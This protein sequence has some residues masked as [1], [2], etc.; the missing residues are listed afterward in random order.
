MPRTTLLISAVILGL[1]RVAPAQ[2]PEDQTRPQSAIVPAA[3]NNSRG[4]SQDYRVGIGDT[5]E[6]QVIEAETLNQTIRVSSAGTINFLPVGQIPVLDLTAAELEA[7]IAAVLQEAKLIQKPEVL[8]FVQ[9]Y[10]A[11]RIYVSGELARPGEFVMSQSMT[12]LDAI[13][14]AGGVTSIAGPRAYLH[15]RTAA[16]APAVPP[17]PNAVQQ[18]EAPREGTE[19]VKIDLQPMLDGGIP[20]PDVMLQ[21]GDALMVPRRH[22]NFY[23]VLGDVMRPL[24]YVYPFGRT[25]MAS[26]ALAGAGGPTKTAR[27][28]EGMVVRY[29]KDGTREERKVDFAAILEGRQPDFTV[30]PDDII[31]VPGSKI[32]TIGEGFVFAANAMI[33]GTAFRV[34]RRYQL[35]DSPNAD[36]Q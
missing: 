3:A 19:I 34:G 2:D 20:E 24:N 35:P 11:K 31:F 14:L 23:Y 36:E 7:K 6:I 8:V 22:V 28:S 16:G 13:L 9:D 4:L 27:M 18:P 25:L 5:L 15:R 32:K 26:Q 10:Q 21:H 1:L 30:M 29:A 12:V 33:E 17:P